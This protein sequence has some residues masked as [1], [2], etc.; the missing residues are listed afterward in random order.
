MESAFANAQGTLDKISSWFNSNRLELN[1]NKTNYI[2]F[3]HF[4]MSSHPTLT[5]NGN[6]VNAVQ[7]AKL[8]GVVL[9]SNLSWNLHIDNI[10][11]KLA[12][13]IGIL[14]RLSKAIPK[15]CLKFAYN[16]FFLPYLTYCISVWG[17]CSRTNYSRLLI[18]QKRAIRI[19]NRLPPLAHIS[20]QFKTLR[21]LSP[22]NCSSLR[23][24]S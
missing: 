6:V 22:L 24:Q 3:S 20:H 5:M 16:A 13:G 18:L 19:V 7:H 12:R 9:S 14:F 23:L 2:L 15:Q 1:I 11:S 8:L 10:S 4:Q 17:N 21:V